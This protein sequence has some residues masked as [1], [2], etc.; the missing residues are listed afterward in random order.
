MP[1]IADLAAR[2]ALLEPSCGPSR[3]VAVDGPGGSGKT[4]FAGL[5]SG[6]L[7]G[8]PVVHS[9]DFPIPWDQGPESWFSHLTRDVLRPLQNGSNASFRRYD[10]RRGVHAERVEVPAAAVVIVEGVSVGRASCPAA[11]RVWVEVPRELRRARVL[12]RDGAEHTADW[13]TWTAAE[14]AWFA[15]NPVVPDARVD[16]V[17]FEVVWA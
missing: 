14:D 12:A 2:I 15:R 8:A 9:D 16:G 4:T 6:A 5:L 10:W 17:T 11:I 3:L 1:T 7:N 13:V